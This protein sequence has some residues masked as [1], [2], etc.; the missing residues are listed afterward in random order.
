MRKVFILNVFCFELFHFL[1]KILLAT[2]RLLPNHLTSWQGGVPVFCSS[3]TGSRVSY[4]C[5]VNP[6]LG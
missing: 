3:S 6:P 1:H 4:V 5:H 2:L